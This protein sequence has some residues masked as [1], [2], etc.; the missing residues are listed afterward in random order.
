MKSLHRRLVT[1]DQGDTKYE[2]DYIVMKSGF[3]YRHARVLSHDEE[4]ISI[5]QDNYP[6]TY[7]AISEIAS[8]RVNRL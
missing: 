1:L 2:L 8:A 5:A 3:V 7:L 4:S 6:E